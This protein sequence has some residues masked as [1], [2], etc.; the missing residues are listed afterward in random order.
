[1]KQQLHQVRY[2]VVIL[3]IS[4]TLFSGANWLLQQL[5]LGVGYWTGFS[6][7]IG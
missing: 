7:I 6:M 3:G 2:S 5:V 4:V 1:M